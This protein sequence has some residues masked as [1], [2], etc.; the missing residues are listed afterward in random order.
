MQA[1]APSPVVRARNIG[2]AVLL[3]FAGLWVGYMVTS[4]D[5]RDRSADDWIALAVIAVVLAVIWRFVVVGPLKRSEGNTPAKA[6]MIAGI[7]GLLSNALFWAGLPLVLGAGAL[8]L[9]VEGRRRAG[10]GQGRAGMAQ[11]AVI[12][13]GVTLA[14]WIVFMIVG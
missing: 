14:A 4:D 2:I 8:V 10:V 9:G 6:G 11:A 7:I 13:G 1:S 5:P 12:L 3:V